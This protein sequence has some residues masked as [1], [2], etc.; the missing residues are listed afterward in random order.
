MNCCE[1]CDKETENGFFNDK[2]WMCN[3][4][5]ESFESKKE[6]EHKKK[7]CN[8]MSGCFNCLD[9]SWRDFY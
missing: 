5:N 2:D 1:W 9:I 3:K 7:G 8:C 4:C 6:E